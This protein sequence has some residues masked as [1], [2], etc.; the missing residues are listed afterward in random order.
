MSVFSND[1]SS[2]AQPAVFWRNMCTCPVG[3]RQTGNNSARCYDSGTLGKDTVKVL[4]VKHRETWRAPNLNVISGN[5]DST[6][7]VPISWIP[8][9]EFAAAPGIPHSPQNTLTASK[10]SGQRSQ[11][12]QVLHQHKKRDEPD[13][14]FSF[15]AIRQNPIE[16]KKN[17][18]ESA[19]KHRQKRRHD[20]KSPDTSEIVLGSPVE[21]YP[22]ESKPSGDCGH[23]HGRH[24]QPRK[25]ISDIKLTPIS[26]AR[27]PVSHVRHK[28]PDS[29]AA[30]ANNLLLA[31]TNEHRRKRRQRRRR[32]RRRENATKL[33]E[34]ISISWRAQF[35]VT[36]QVNSTSVFLTCARYFI[37]KSLKI[38]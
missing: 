4:P 30:V 35:H 11:N 38:G 36:H 16:A 1:D 34:S 13:N 33:I 26:S 25:G 21:P 18:D 23:K 9:T 31:K 15:E 37:L 10:I 29:P 22:V 7:V 28:N 12:S 8:Q 20:K 27:P 2:S 6:H 19:D 3:R 17:F 32:R 14:Q 5:R 24:R